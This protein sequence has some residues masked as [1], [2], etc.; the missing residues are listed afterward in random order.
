MTHI[1]DKADIYALTVAHG[2][3]NIT[4]N[5]L[6]GETKDYN[7]AV[8]LLLNKEINGFLVVNHGLVHYCVRWFNDFTINRC[9]I[10]GQGRSASIY[11]SVNDFDAIIVQNAC[12]KRLN[13]IKGFRERS[14]NYD[15]KD[16]VNT[17]KYI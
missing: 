15:N 4:N 14:G 8:N 16:L 9:E 13:L 17:Y 3:F 12:E 2:N 1:F 11:D 10:T 6:K 7:K 5:P